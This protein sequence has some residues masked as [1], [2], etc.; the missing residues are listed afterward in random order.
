[1]VL[2]FAKMGGM[3]ERSLRLYPK[4]G[5]L[6]IGSDADIVVLDKNLN[7]EYV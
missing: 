5:C 3:I 2:S 4:K 7:I 1:M 6:K